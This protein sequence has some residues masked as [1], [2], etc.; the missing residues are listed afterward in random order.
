MGLSTTAMKE[1][2][3][4]LERQKAY[5][6]VVEA[7]IGAL[8]CILDSGEVALAAE[9]KVRP[10]SS[11]STDSVSPRPS[12]RANILRTLQ[13]L[14]KAT[15]AELTARLRQD[16][17][18]VGG[19]TSLRERVWHELSRLRRNDFIRRTRGGRYQLRQTK[20][21]LRFAVPKPAD[22]KSDSTAMN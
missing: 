15:P 7:R 18:Q 19:A 4:E 11:F 20:P 6:T 8:Q 14:S 16:G 10:R 13:Q 17:V 5:R 12:L 3:D 2:R 1:L 22:P 9:G 21:S